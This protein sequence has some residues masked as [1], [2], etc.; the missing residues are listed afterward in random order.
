MRVGDLVDEPREDARLP[1]RTT[2]NGRD[3]ET[4]R[5]TYL[6][7]P[8]SEKVQALRDEGYTLA[9]I[10]ARHLTMSVETLHRRRREAKC[11]GL[12]H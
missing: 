10:A 11:R 4:C 6:L 12:R 3:P 9:E 2:T 7:D 8:S 1:P 5:T